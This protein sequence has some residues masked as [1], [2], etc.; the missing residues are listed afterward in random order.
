VGLDIACCDEW[1][2]IARVLIWLESE[3][4]PELRVQPSVADAQGELIA[5][6]YCPH[7]GC[8]APASIRAADLDVDEDI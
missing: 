8:P 4:E 2:E 3:E 7:C 5:V 1:P 6:L